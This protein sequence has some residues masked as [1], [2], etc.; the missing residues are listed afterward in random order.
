MSSL[1][2]RFAE[3]NF[4][5][6]RYVER[7]E[8]LAR[9]LDVN[10]TFARDSHGAQDWLPIVQLQADESRFFAVHDRATAR[11]VVQFYVVDRDNPTSI[12]SAVGMA[13]ENARTLR[14]LI[15]TE[16]WR[17]LNVFYNRLCELAPENL[18]LAEL[19]NLCAT[20]KESCQTHTGITEGTFYRD[21]D[22][23]FYQLGKFIERA[24]QT[25]RLLDIKYHRLL[26]SVED[27]GS[28][29]DIGQWNA[30]LRS[31]AGYHAFRR[32]HPRG[33]RP[34]NV[35][36]FL[37][38]NPNFPRSAMICV[39]QLDAILREFEIRFG[40][41]VTATGSVAELFTAL[42]ARDIDDVMREGLHDFLDWIQ[43]RL[44]A[45]TNEMG[46]TLFGHGA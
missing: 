3:N 19:A 42:E 10:E 13:R 43:L 31:V 30:L 18:T 38:F 17:H 11:S 46:A 22:W 15:S 21:Q 39:R 5:M 32:V 41:R 7:A 44:I 34:A 9:I 4:W 35:A 36:G 14:H 37:L 8:N 23:Y 28:P 16:M 6:A 40:L 1:L 45:L 2:A 27:V 24:D 12:I 20:V 33:M 25:T 26:P 29:V